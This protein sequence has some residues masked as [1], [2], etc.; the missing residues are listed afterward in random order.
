MMCLQPF[1][2]ETKMIENAKKAKRTFATVSVEDCVNGALRDLG[3]EKTT[4]GP[5]KHD[6][7]CN[8]LSTIMRYVPG[9]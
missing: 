5:L 2:V 4:Y 9:G 7:V 1:Y 6:F 3:H 8:V